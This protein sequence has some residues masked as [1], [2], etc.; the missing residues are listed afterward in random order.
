MNPA[1]SFAATLV[2][3]CIADLWLYWSA[4]FVGTTIIAFGLRKKMIEKIK[5]KEDD[6]KV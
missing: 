2:S 3:G 6:I 4:T 5:M 1:R